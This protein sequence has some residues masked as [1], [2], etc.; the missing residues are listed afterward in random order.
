MILVKVKGIN[1][2]QYISSLDKPAKKNWKY[3]EK[4]N[5]DLEYMRIPYDRIELRKFM[6][7]WE[8]QPIRGECRRWAFGLEYPDKL[9]RQGKLRLFVAVKKNGEKIAMH[10]VEVHDG[11]VECHPPMYDKA[12]YSK[13]YLAKYM[14][15]NLFK[16]AINQPDMEWIDLGGG[17]DGD[18]IEMIKTRDQYPNP[19]YKWMYVPEY[20]KKY[21][22][23]Q[24][25]FAL[26]LP[27]GKLGDIK[28]LAE[29]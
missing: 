12:K 4:H 9:E 28:F 2:E 11:Y 19:R 26:R 27:Q 8:Q 29:I 23:R 22:D 24:Q 14:W 3:V 18:W 17:N 16:Y 1:F 21:P 6:D 25:N 15:F 5:Q 10:F 13:R 7:L 20:V